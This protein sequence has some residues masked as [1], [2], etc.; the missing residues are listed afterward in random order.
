MKKLLIPLVMMC[1]GIVSVKAQVT[2]ISTID[3]VVYLNPVTA[4]AGT[5]CVLSVK[6]KNIPSIAGFE[7]YLSLPDGLTFAKDEEDFLLTSLS[8]A[9]TTSK[10]TS[11]FEGTVNDAGLLHV[12][13]ST[14]KEDPATNKL[15]TFSGNDGEVC[16]VVIDIPASFE[17]GT[18]P[19]VLTEIVMT[20]P[21]TENNYETERLETTITVE[22]SDGRIHFDESATL[23][24]SYTD[25][26]TGDITM[27]RTI[28]ANEWSTICLP[29]TLPMAD[30]KAIF[31]SDVELYQFGGFE[32]AYT[33]DEDVTPDAIIINFT[34]YSLTARNPMRGGQP[35]LIKTTRDI[36]SFEANS[37]KLCNVV[38]PTQKDDAYYTTG[39]FRGSLVKTQIP[40]DGLF[41]SSNKFWYSTGKTTTKAFRCWF[42]LG[43]VLNK[44]TEDFES[45]IFLSF[46]NDDTTGISD[47]NGKKKDA[48]YAVYDLQ[49]RK[50]LK[51]VKGLYIKNGRKEVVK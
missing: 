14:T 51:P 50:V 5:Q 16:T 25:G 19:I 39:W 24:P 21:D 2:D 3:N 26:E 40:E 35:Y 8:N 34:P 38:T 47:V 13:C 42:D 11:F 49:G 22:V 20:E 28:K 33:D 15:Y 18:Y 43:A 7:F 17:A 44:E 46:T 4:N 27:Q 23:L 6:M 41:I 12:L 37:V 30:A 45:R 31:G 32:V 10:R 48:R 9:R 29:F 36:E 1:L